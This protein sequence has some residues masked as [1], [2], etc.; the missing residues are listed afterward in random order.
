MD[1]ELTVILTASYIPSHPKILLIREVIESLKL[2]E[3]KNSTVFD[4]CK[5]ILAHDHNNNNN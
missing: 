4:K 5:I 3:Y 2:I 1:N